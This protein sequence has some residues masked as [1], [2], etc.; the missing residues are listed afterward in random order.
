VLAAPLLVLALVACGTPSSTRS[1]EPAPR[2]TQCTVT[3]RFEDATPPDE[4]P[5]G[6]D[7][8][9]SVVALPHTRVTLVRICEPGGTETR[10]VGSEL[11]V[12]QFGD[13]G[14]ALLRARCWW[15]G[16]GSEIEVHRVLRQLVVRRAV[17][18]EEGGLGPFED[19]VELATPAGA[20]LNVLGPATLPHPGL[21]AP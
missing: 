7:G 4:G 11:G 2:R 12:C 3:L 13:P 1:V 21:R 10:V 16:D 6:A 19:V 20:E 8:T 14:E 15:A 5:E 17:L 18:T 9:P